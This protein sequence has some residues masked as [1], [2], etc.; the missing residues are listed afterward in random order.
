M[1]AMVMLLACSRSM[2]LT[3]SL[4]LASPQ[5]RTY[6]RSMNAVNRCLREQNPAKA[7]LEGWPDANGY[8]VARLLGK[9]VSMTANFVDGAGRTVRSASIATC[10][11]APKH[12]DIAA[13]GSSLI[14]SWR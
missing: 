9:P 2:R 13:F 5:K 1:A 3:K 10:A 7:S 6:R 4:P 12:D 11:S 8:S 14:L